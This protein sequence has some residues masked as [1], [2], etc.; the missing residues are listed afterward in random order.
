MQGG[1]NDG[2]ESHQLLHDSDQKF[3]FSVQEESETYK[4]SPAFH[5]RHVIEEPDYSH[6]YSGQGDNKGRG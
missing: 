1:G 6:Y 3:T 4:G 2:H 5:D